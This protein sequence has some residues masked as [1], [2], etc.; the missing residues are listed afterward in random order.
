M[1]GRLLRRLARLVSTMVGLTSLAFC[2]SAQRNAFA[3]NPI[4][5]RN[6]RGRI[7]EHRTD[8]LTVWQIK[9]SRFDRLE[10]QR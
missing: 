9:E 6:G 1:N 7:C 8:I 2:A 5:L 4:E 10:P 3:N